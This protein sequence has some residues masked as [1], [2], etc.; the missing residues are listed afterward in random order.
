MNRRRVCIS[1]LTGFCLIFEL[2]H[3]TAEGVPVGSLQ[4]SSQGIFDLRQESVQSGL[5]NNTVYALEEDQFGFMWIGTEN[6]LNRYDSREWV[7]YYFDPADSTG[8]SN[9]KIQTLLSDQQGRLWIGTAKGL[10]LFSFNDNT[11]IRLPTESGKDGLP[12][13]YIRCLY[14]DTD[15]DIWVG[16]S[17]GLSRIPSSNSGLEI[18]H[19]TLGNGSDRENNIVDIYEDSQGLIWIGTANGLFYTRNKIDFFR[20]ELALHHQEAVKNV[21]VRSLIEVGNAFLIATENNGLIAYFHD[22]GVLQKLKV[23]NDNGTPREFI[24]RDLFIDSDS[25]LWLASTSGAFRVKKEIFQVDL[26]PQGFINADQVLSSSVRVVFQD[27]NQGLWM[28]TQYTGLYSH[29]RDN[30]LFNKIR[31][32]PQDENGLSNSVVSSFL[33]EGDSVW[34]GTDG[35]GLNLW[36]RSQNLFRYWTVQEGMVNNNVKCLSRDWK[37]RLWIGTFKGLSIFTGSTFRNYD[38]T[39]LPGQDMNAP[40]NHILSIYVDPVSGLAWLGTDGFGLF[41][42]NQE[43]NMIHPVSLNASVLA[44]SSINQIVPVNDSILILGTS[45]GLYEFN[46]DAAMFHQLPIQV[47]GL[48]E[49]EPYIITLEPQADQK[50]WIGT[51]KYGL[52]LYDLSAGQATLVKAF[53]DVKGIAINAIRQT[54]SGN[55]WCSTNQGLTHIVVDMRPDS[56]VVLGSSFYT[57]SYG[58]QSRQFMPRA[59]YVTQQNE[60]FFGGISGFNYFYPESISDVTQEIPTYIRSLSYWNDKEDQMVEMNRVF[61]SGEQLEFAH[62]IRDITL[63]FIGINFSHPEN[64]RYAYRISGE[65]ENWI[66]LGTRN[67]IT[68]NRLPHGNYHIE[69]RSSE[70]PDQWPG[71][72]TILDIAILPPLWKSGLAVTLY[73]FTILILLYLFYRTII[74]WERLRSDLNVEQLRREQE[75]QLHEHRIRFFTDISHELRTPLTLILS[76]I[77]MIIKNQPVSMRVRNILLMVKQNGEKMLQLINQLLDL[78]KAETGHL[79]FQAARGNLVKFLQEVMLS[80]RDLAHTRD[81]VLEF[82]SR[83]KE[84]DAYYD[85]NKLEIVIT[86]L[87]SN[88]IKHTPPGGKITLGIED[89]PDKG[90]HAISSF[91]DGFIQIL[92]E[93]TGEGIPADKLEKIFDRFYEENSNLKGIGIGLELSKKYVELHSGTIS[94]ESQVQQENSAGYSRFTIRLPLGRRHLSDDQIAKDFIGSEDIRSYT[95]PAQET[96]LHP[97]LEI[98]VKK[99]EGMENTKSGNYRLIVIEDNDELRQFLLQMLGDQYLVVGAENGGIGW[100]MILKDPPDLV[101][102]DIM[103]PG[104]DGIELCRKVKTDI[105]TSHIPVI[106]L[107]ARTAITFKYEGLE[108]GADEYI[109]KPFHTE[110]LTLRVRNLLYQ[111]EMVRRKYLR[112]SITDPEVITLTSMDE[113]LLKK[114][115]DYIHAH[116]DQN[117]LSIESI[118]EYLGISRVHFYRKI[119]SIAGVTPQEF[120]KTVRLKYAAALLT[121]KKL[122]ISE[123]AYMCGY[124]DLAHFSRTFKEFYGVSPSRYSEESPHLP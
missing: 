5:S 17:E 105:R 65:G 7:C 90:D 31:Y 8:I 35:G 78:R 93:D 103:M 85:R 54:D 68:L 100:E 57:E 99:L 114:A 117:E 111:R 36:I 22:S 75:E 101:I 96:A 53:G 108:T 94:V 70:E 59:S 55:L 19:T 112:E 66:D 27:S 1:I 24:Y 82:H 3:L 48:G 13:E 122:R 51:E 4:G 83:L 25:T 77:D 50:L 52:I 37:G 89:H 119:K 49:I 115:I 88:A 62:Y 56:V 64:T 73:L 63:E 98:E 84:I 116:M 110:Y 118:S 79:K 15:L 92:I 18:Q 39:A 109:T 38:F 72:S 106:L 67:F 42:F 107:T 102:S 86:N 26:F 97:D 47:K 12:G 33:A 120:L 69:I 123:V 80:F 60:L 10:N 61:P 95:A 76:P 74:R 9:S 46:K 30:F 87:L 21:Q 41:S 6:G 124:R 11:F 104:M 113:K 71:K 2:L 44:A 121:Q 81:I 14:E 29:Y 28:G 58:I 34:I 91:P 32:N 16:T 20:F 45:S 23:V 43:S 40:S